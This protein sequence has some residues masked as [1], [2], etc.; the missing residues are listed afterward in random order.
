ALARGRLPDLHQEPAVPRELQDHVVVERGARLALTLVLLP[1]LPR[2]RLSAAGGRTAASVA[3]DPHVPFVVDG[4]A[5]VRVRPVVAWSGAAPVSDEGA[6]RVELQDRRRRRAALR[7]RRRRRRVQLA[8][9]QGA[10]A[11]DDPYVILG[12]DRDAD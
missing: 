3:A 9:F 2:R 10:G 6:G 4:D 8:G 1:V 7:G 5:V 11:M 12:V